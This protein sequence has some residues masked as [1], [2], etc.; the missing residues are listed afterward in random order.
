MLWGSFGRSL[1]FA[2]CAALAY[3][4]YWVTWRVAVGGE[5]P[6]EFFAAA[7]LGV[8][9]AGVAPR[10]SA[11]VRAGFAALCAGLLISV[12]PLETET[13]LVGMALLLGVFRSAVLYQRRL[14]RA[15]FV[16]A[17]LLGS[18]ALLA[19]FVGGPGPLGTAAGVWGF[20]LMQSLYFLVPGVH[21]RESRPK[22]EDPF[23]R[24]WAH[25]HSV[26]GDG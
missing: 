16:E 8:Y 9:A 10:P 23:E 7:C 19:A 5:A 25:A 22:G 21:P 14:A 24:A 17:V 18:G 15:V 6:P 26:L 2:A 11:A 1:L 13:R 12:F 20:F 3:P 4:A